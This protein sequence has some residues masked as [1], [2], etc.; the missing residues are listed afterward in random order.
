MGRA[1]DRAAYRETGRRA[2]EGDDEMSALLAFAHGQDR[3]KAVCVGP[4][5]IHRDGV[6]E[7]HG[8]GCAGIFESFHDGDS[9]WPC[10]RVEGVVTRHLCGRCGGSVRRQ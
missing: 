2:A 4:V 10:H 5:L 9:T 1:E 6:M 3:R 7:C 8:R